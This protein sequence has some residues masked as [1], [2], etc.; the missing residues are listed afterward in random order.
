MAALEHRFQDPQLLASALRH[1]SVGADNYER[2]EFLGDAV[3]GKH[4]ALRLFERLED[5][6][7]SLLSQ[8]RAALVRKETLASIARGL[9]LG[10]AL[11]LGI[12]ERKTAV[13]SRDSVLADALE[14]LVGAVFLDG[15]DD[16]AAALIDRLFADRLD[17]LA[18]LE[19]KDSKTRLQE[20]LQGIGL[21]LPEYRVDATSGAQ[22]RQTFTVCCF[23]KDLGLETSGQGRSRRAAEKAAALAMLRALEDRG[24]IAVSG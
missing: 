14:A 8:T 7:E 22:H 9:E 1:R 10:G 20:A 15:G 16:A 2:L 18:A 19:T 4:I 3:L 12:S 5:A 23:L 6:P 17:D 24:T 11:E 21:P 13:Q